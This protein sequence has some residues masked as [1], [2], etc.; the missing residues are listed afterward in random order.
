MARLMISF[1]IWGPLTFQEWKTAF[2]KQILLDSKMDGFKQY[3]L[4]ELAKTKQPVAVQQNP[5]QPAG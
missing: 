3:K 5:T 1:Q 4:D 2:K